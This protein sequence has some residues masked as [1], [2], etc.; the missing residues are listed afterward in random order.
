MTVHTPVLLKE[1][2]DA[3]DLKEGEIF[4]DATFGAGGHSREV[5]RRFDSSIE[6]IA[7]D[8]DPKVKEREKEFDVKTL[9]FRDIDQ[10]LEGKQA[11]A[12]LIDL[13]FSSDQMENSNRGFSFMR[14]EPLDMR[15]SGDGITAADIINSWDEDALELVL[16]GFGEEKHS[17]SIAKAI[18][19]RR[20]VELFKTTFDLVDVIAKIRQRGRRE[21]IHPATK[22]FQALRIATNE[23]LTSL[24]I[25]LVKGFESLSTGGRFV[26]ISFHS[27]EDRLV[28]NFFR[29]KVREGAA[30]GI[31]KKPITATEEET[32]RNPR[33]RSAKMRVI[34]KL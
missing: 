14:D 33:S 7:L 20:E 30:Q 21:K 34:E 12:I 29:D 4:V 27:L 23:E 31:T 19:E 3:L 9:N 13:G 26:I 22:T 8:Q 11:D 32:E 25:V 5:R 18:V 2:V 6:I 1:S 16:R 17:R 24:E 10:A 15:M 28:K